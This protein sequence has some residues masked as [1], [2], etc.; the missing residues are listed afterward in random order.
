MDGL[1]QLRQAYTNYAAQQQSMGL[2]AMPFEQFVQASQG[3]TQPQPQQDQGRPVGLL[4]ALGTGRRP[5]NTAQLEAL[6]RAR[7]DIK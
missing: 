1:V 2:P 3:R 5:A 6:L 4:E 7:G